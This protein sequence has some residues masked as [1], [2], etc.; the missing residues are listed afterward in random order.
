MRSFFSEMRY[1]DPTHRKVG[2]FRTFSRAPH[3]GA[4]LEK[5]C[6]GIIRVGLC[7]FIICTIGYYPWH[8]L[9]NHDLT[10]D[11]IEKERESIHLQNIRRAPIRRRLIA[12]KGQ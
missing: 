6:W 12:L 1:S 7:P 10:K 2:I 9:G 8:G 5:F 11:V 3:Q 4:K